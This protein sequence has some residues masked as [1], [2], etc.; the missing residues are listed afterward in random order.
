MVQ[1]RQVGAEVLRSQSVGYG[2]YVE[3]SRREKGR[4]VG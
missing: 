1:V 3:Y 2:G 4:G